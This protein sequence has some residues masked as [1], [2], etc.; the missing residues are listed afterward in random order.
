MN[1]FANKSHLKQLHGQP[2]NTFHFFINCQENII[3]TFFLLAW[4]TDIYYFRLNCIYCLEYTF[5]FKKK[6]RRK[7]IT[8]CTIFNSTL[9][10]SFC[11]C[12]V[13]WGKEHHC[14][15]LGVFSW[16][17]IMLNVFLYH[18]TPLL[19]RSYQNVEVKK[20]NNMS[21]MWIKPIGKIWVSR[22]S[23]IHCYHFFN[24]FIL[25][26]GHEYEKYLQKSKSW[27]IKLP[28]KLVGWKYFLKWIVMN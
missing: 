12:V 14:F 18:R 1:N 11:A 7:R 21:N 9:C 25:T 2:N 6:R 17:Y 22:K 26:Q 19:Q 20:M 10:N 24:I 13:S 3:H 23:L 28:N 8:Y 5:T 15:A 16:N 27:S 4:S